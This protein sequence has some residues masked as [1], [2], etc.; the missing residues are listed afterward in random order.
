MS[1][2]SLRKK[3]KEKMS[4]LG[5]P[6]A[7]IDYLWDTGEKADKDK[8]YEILLKHDI[9]FKAANNATEF[10]EKYNSWKNDNRCFLYILSHADS[11][12]IFTDKNE[13]NRIFLSDL[14]KINNADTV[15]FAS[16]NS[17]GIA[18]YCFDK[19][20][21]SFIGTKDFVTHIECLKCV[22]IL[23]DS[24]Y[25]FDPVRNEWVY[26]VESNSVLIEKVNKQLGKEL[27]VLFE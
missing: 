17:E 7:V 22:N 11:Q 8:F 16:C 3:A 20:H 14:E 4:N 21:K 13:N 24:M 25:Q 19:T 27:F 2:K 12:G 18:K 15:V 9:C 26:N 23:F 10:W 5:E 1:K 6:I